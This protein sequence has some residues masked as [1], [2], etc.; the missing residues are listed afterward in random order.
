[1]RGRGWAISKN[2]LLHTINA[3]KNHARGTLGKKSSK[4]FFFFFFLNRSFVRSY[5][6][7]KYHAQPKIEKKK[8]C[9][10]KL[11]TSTSASPCQ[12]NNVRPWEPKPGKSKLVYLISKICLRLTCPSAIANVR[13]CL[14]F[15]R[16]AKL[17]MIRCSAPRKGKWGLTTENTIA[18][19]VTSRRVIP[20][21]L[22]HL[23]VTF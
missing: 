9:P 8:Q 1:M 7:P 5:C 2:E 10:I 6:P 23:N 18:G 14:T 22:L 11:A 4:C 17:L 20:E 12:K 16:T 13:G 19:V 21:L 3:E 15:Q